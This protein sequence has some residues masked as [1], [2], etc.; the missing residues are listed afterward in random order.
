MLKHTITLPA[1]LT[2]SVKYFTYSGG[3]LVFSKEAFLHLDPSVIRSVQDSSKTIFLE[4]RDN[5]LLAINAKDGTVKWKIKNLSGYNYIGVMA[6]Q[7]NV[8]ASDF[9]GIVYAF[10]IETGA[11]KWSVPV[12]GLSSGQSRPE[13]TGDLIYAGST[14]KN[15]YILNRS[16][17]TQK[18]VIST[19]RGVQPSLVVA[20]QVVYAGTEDYDNKFYAFDATTGQQN[21]VYPVKK[22][23]FSKPTVT[24]GIV[25]M[26]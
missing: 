1:S 20:D 8:Y 16:D 4:N 7:Q 3:S 15:I 22:S 24:E 14:Q 13:L 26:A 12:N 5:D 18:S 11:K 2:V 17:G 9:G 6:D 25:Y 21:W 10:D 19:P 23:F